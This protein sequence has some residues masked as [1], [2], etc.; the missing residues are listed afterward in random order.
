MPGGLHPPL[1]VILSWPKPSH[2]SAA[3]RHGIVIFSCVLTVLA[4]LVVMA[5]LRARYYFTA[6]APLFNILRQLC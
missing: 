2:E 3:A 6:H 1:D 5:R 4:I